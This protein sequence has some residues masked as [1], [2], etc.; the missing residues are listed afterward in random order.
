MLSRERVEE[1]QGMDIDNPSSSKTLNSRALLAL[2]A[3]QVLKTKRKK[4]TS[5]IR[6]QLQSF[7]RDLIAHQTPRP[8]KGFPLVVR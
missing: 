7:A 8:E 6:Q 4:G 5:F 3:N 1:M 2:A